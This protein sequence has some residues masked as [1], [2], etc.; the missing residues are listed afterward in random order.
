V[1]RE[2]Q[3]TSPSVIYVPHLNDWWHIVNDAV[4][5]TFMSLL[6]DLDPCIPVLLLATTDV[7]FKRLP[8]QVRVL[9]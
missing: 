7:E 5:A 2:A 3:R 4:R 9:H 6:N 8:A 1:L